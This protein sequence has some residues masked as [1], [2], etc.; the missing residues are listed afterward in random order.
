MSFY[1]DWGVD[2][3][4]TFIHLLEYGTRGE[5]NRFKRQYKFCSLLKNSN[6]RRLMGDADALDC[7]ITV[8]LNRIYEEYPDFNRLDYFKRSPVRPSLSNNFSVM[9]NK[10]NSKKDIICI[11]LSIFR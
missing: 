3:L 9:W 5:I 10:Y 7:L 8:H 11:L 1:V 2:T 4:N 6:N